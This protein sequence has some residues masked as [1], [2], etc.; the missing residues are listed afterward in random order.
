MLLLANGGE[1]VPQGGGGGGGGVSG[2]TRQQRRW[3]G[4]AV[5]MP[6]GLVGVCLGNGG[7]V[8]ARLHWR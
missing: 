4:V 5:E 2:V 3:R 1:I 6:A 8:V 7:G